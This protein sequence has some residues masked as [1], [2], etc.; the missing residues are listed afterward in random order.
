VAGSPEFR[1]T[2]ALRA[3]TGGGVDFVVI[4]GLAVVVHGHIRTTR[5]VDITYDAAP[6]N[7]DALGRVLIGLDARLRGVEEI[8]PFVP[9]G[10]A[11]RRVQILTLDTDA[12][13]ID[14]LRAASKLYTASFPGSLYRLTRAKESS[15]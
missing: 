5:D 15:D 1:P 3:L 14:L 8:V 9:D 12:G 2:Q 13:W 10:R 4:G 6:A 11:L 7:L